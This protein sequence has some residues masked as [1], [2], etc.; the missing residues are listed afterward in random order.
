[1]LV[2]GKKGSEMKI[3]DSL[4]VDIPGKGRLAVDDARLW[5][6][7]RGLRWCIGHLLS[8]SMVDSIEYGSFMSSNVPPKSSLNARLVSVSR[9]RTSIAVRYCLECEG[10][11]CKG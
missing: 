3:R 5:G 10:I 6:D 4:G 11:T 2:V 9:G 8:T 7:R 1:M